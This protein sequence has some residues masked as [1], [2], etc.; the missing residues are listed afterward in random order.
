M[1]AFKKESSPVSGLNGIA[2]NM[3]EISNDFQNNGMNGA[4][5]SNEGAWP[6]RKPCG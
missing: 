6:G 1:D 3:G 4:G 5:A 2:M